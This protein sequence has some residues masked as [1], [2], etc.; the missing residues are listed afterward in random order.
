MSSA[1]ISISHRLN[2]D[3]VASS[4]FFSRPPPERPGEPARG[5]D[6]ICRDFFN[7]LIFILNEAW[8]GVIRTTSTEEIHK[9]QQKIGIPSCPFGKHLS[10]FFF[11]PGPLLAC[12]S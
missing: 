11:L 5:L 2:R 10:H 12:F 6:K 4:P 3:V 8:I 1:Q 9:A 7:S